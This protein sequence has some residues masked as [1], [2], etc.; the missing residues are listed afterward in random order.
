M[1]PSMGACCKYHIE[2]GESYKGAAAP[3]RYKS[4][5]SP[6]MDFIRLT[7]TILTGNKMKQLDF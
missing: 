6:S 4:V 5:P 3:F 2:L 1:H 7:L